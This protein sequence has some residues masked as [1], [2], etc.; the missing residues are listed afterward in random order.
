MYADYDD[1]EFRRLRRLNPRGSAEFDRAETMNEL[2]GGIG[3]FFRRIGEAF[4]RWRSRR[5]TKDELASLDDHA[6]AD[7]GMARADIPY[8]AAVDPL[9]PTPPV[10]APIVPAPDEHEGDEFSREAEE[11]RRRATTAI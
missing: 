8:V 1:F 3:G 4:A 2:G 10:D 6:L 5:V 9:A 7:I 11:A